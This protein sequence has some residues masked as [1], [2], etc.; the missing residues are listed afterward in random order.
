MALESFE[1]RGVLLAQVEEGHAGGRDGLG[2]VVALGVAGDEEA[3]RSRHGG[4]A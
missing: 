3:D 1:R 2:V 4:D